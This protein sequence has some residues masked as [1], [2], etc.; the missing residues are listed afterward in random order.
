MAN[1]I[2][3]R[4]FTDYIHRN[5]ALSKIYSI[6]NWRQLNLD[7]SFAQ[8][9]D[10]QKGIDYIFRDING[11]IK[12]VQ[13]RFR[14]VK[15]QNYSD[16]TIR[17][18]RDGNIYKSRHKSE[19]YKIRANYFTYGITNCYK[20]NLASCTDFIKFAVID[21]KKVY[22]KIDSGDI[23]IED[24]RQN[25]CIIKSNK[26]V[27]PIKY[28]RDGSSSFFPIEISYLVRLWGEEIIV[29]QKGFI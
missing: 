3:D 20:T 27:C 9:I 26:I 2:T 1:Y 13:E 17:Y 19:Y 6:L 11:N 10:M 22:E 21:L 24:N 16:F 7:N 14:E 15:Y 12:T 29:L 23:I 25:S 4:A 8:K 18:R 5:L 28:N